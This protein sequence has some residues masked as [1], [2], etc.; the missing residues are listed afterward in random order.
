MDVN[1]QLT[2][3]QREIVERANEVLAQAKAF[4]T[5]ETTGKTNM[6]KPVMTTTTT[7]NGADMTVE[8]K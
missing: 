7:V 3:E 4:M 8:F 5:P 1:E 2:P 6:S